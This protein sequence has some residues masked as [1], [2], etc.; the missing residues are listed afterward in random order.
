MSKPGWYNASIALDG[1]EPGRDTLDGR[2]TWKECAGSKGP[3]RFRS[4]HPNRQ[5]TGSQR[6]KRLDVSVLKMI[7][8]QRFEYY[9]IRQLVK[10]EWNIIL[11]LEKN[12]IGIANGGR[13][14]RR[15]QRTKKEL[16]NLNADHRMTSRLRSPTVWTNK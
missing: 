3:G 13:N 11:Y 15:G 6:S 8:T 7:G 10:T 16:I 14:R 4:Q 12:F 9:L 5:A 2:G 1:G